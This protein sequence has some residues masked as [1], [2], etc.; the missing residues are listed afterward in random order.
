MK[1]KQYIKNNFSWEGMKQLVNKKLE[2]VVL[3]T[4]AAFSNGS[5]GTL[6]MGVE[7]DLN[8]IGL[9]ND[10]KTLRNGT[11]D[12]FELHLRN[13][14][15]NAYGVEF[16]TNSLTVLFPEVEDT[17]ICTIEIKQGL[18]PLYSEVSDKNGNRSK[19]FYVRSGNS[20]QAIDITEVASYINQR[21]ELT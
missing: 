12:E 11:K 20:S 3:K 14:V 19:K 2:E 10:Y 7:D 6:I 13:L 8:I 16:A 21:F 17:E 5:G 9:E 18:K 15:N 4:I 1:Q